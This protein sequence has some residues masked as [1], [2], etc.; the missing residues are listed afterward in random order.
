MNKRLAIASVLSG[1]II[2][3]GADAAETKTAQAEQAPATTPAMTDEQQP[4][5]QSQAA[6]ETMAADSS[7]RIVD[8]QAENQLLTKDLIGAEVTGLSAALEN[9]EEQNIGEID[10]LVID[11]EGRVAAAILSVGGFLGIGDK[12][13]GV[14]WDELNIATTEDG[15]KISASLDKAQLE[16]APDYKTQT[17]LQAE[18]QAEQARQQLQEQQPAQPAQPAQ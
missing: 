4:V 12:L 1:L 6:T 16:Q 10:S 11:E 18:L 13:V 7:E 9:P 2:A 17:Q 5:D 8:Q 3:A 15:I 14:S